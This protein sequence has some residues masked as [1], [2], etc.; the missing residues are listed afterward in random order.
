MTHTSTPPPPTPLPSSAWHQIVLAAWLK[1]LPAPASHQNASYFGRLECYKRQIPLLDRGLKKKRD[2]IYSLTPFVCHAASKWGNCECEGAGYSNMQSG[3]K[4]GL[5]ITAPDWHQDPNRVPLQVT[6]IKH[7]QKTVVCVVLYT[8][9]HLQVPL[10]KYVMK[11]TRREKNKKRLIQRLT[12]MRYCFLT[13]SMWHLNYVC[14]LRASD[15]MDQH[16]GLFLARWNRCITLHR[17]WHHC[18]QQPDMNIPSSYPRLWQRRLPPF[19]VSGCAALCGLCSFSFP[20]PMKRDPVVAVGG[21]SFRNDRKEQRLWNTSKAFFY[22]DLRLFWHLKW[23]RLLWG[24]LKSKANRSACR[25]IR[26]TPE[27][28]D[29]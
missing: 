27:G 7:D 1:C 12:E 11:H 13:V 24:E 22:L 19:Q 9:N 29:H 8:W 5:I 21:A 20:D 16:I 14:M 15:D 4:A 2:A 3:S 18:V 17:P 23:L 10:A 28:G 26:W 6:L 25:N